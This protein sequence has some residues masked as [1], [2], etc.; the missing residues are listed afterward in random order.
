MFIH[1][2]HYEYAAWLL[3][4]QAAKRS[5]DELHKTAEISAVRLLPATATPAAK[6]AAVEGTTDTAG[7]KFCTQQ[8]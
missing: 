6:V 1:T 3:T 5:I 2:I 8:Q 4:L 7:N